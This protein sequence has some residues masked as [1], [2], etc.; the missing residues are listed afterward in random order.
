MIVDFFIASF[1]TLV[2]DFLNLDP[3]FK[4]NISQLENKLISC[5]I[6]GCPILIYMLVD[7]ARIKIFKNKIREPDASLSGPP[8]SILRV[9]CSKDKLK[10]LFDS[11]VKM[12]GN[13]TVLDN[14]S[15]VM[16]HIK[17]D[18]EEKLSELIGDFSAHYI[19]NAASQAKR[20]VS[21]VISTLGQDSSEYLREEINLVATPHELTQFKKEIDE[22]RDDVERLAARIQLLRIQNA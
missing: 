1:E 12:S 11:S 2:N 19:T 10:S 21:N 6:S 17:I 7:K 16:S 18:Y 14:F 9:F 3:E 22:L 4:D 8:F 20:Y 15:E 13:T 5:K